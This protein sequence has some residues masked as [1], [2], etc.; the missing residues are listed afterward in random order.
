MKGMMDFSP[1]MLGADSKMTDA[2]RKSPSFNN[3]P[4]IEWGYNKWLNN[5]KAHQYGALSNELRIFLL[6]PTPTKFLLHQ[7]IFN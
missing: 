1:Y 2:E 5:I 4:K 3:L 6:L 7:P